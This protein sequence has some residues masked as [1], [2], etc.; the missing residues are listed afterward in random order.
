MDSDKGYVNLINE[1]EMKEVS[2]LSPTTQKKKI[3]KTKYIES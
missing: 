3:E 2:T 1:S